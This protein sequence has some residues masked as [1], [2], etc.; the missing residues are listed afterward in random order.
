VK[1]F[2]FCQIFQLTHDKVIKPVNRD[3]HV[4][5]I[6]RFIA[7]GDTSGINE[8]AALRGKNSSNTWINSNTYGRRDSQEFGQNGFLT[9][10]K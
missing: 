10:T 3:M 2:A 8:S 1:H 6:C 7:N 9:T 5:L 4:A